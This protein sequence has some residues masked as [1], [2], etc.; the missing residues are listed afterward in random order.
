MHHY[1]TVVAR[2]PLLVRANVAEIWREYIPTQALKHGFLLHGLLAF[3]ALHLT[4]SAQGTP[5]VA[6]YLALCDKHQAVAVSALRDA[7]DG[8]VTA[9]N[10]GALFALA[11]TTSISSMARSCAVANAS[12]EPRALSVEEIAEVIFL[13]KGMR[14]VTGVTADFVRDTPIAFLLVRHSLEADEREGLSLPTA[15]AEQ[16][17]A[18][19]EMLHAQCKDLV[20]NDSA[21]LPAPLHHKVTSFIPVKLGNRLEEIQEVL[22][23]GLIELRDQASIDEDQLRT[24]SFLVNLR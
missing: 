1:S 5:E 24:V 7:L 22:T 6:R 21:R 18:L 12:P 3:S 19:R 8:N 23:V 4:D 15:V 11:A 14:E 20:V 2:E 9:E 10:S 13:T 16:F 17:A